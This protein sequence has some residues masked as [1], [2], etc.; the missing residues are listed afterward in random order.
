MGQELGCH[1]V[2][3]TGKPEKPA[4]SLYHH[5][6]L[7]RAGLYGSTRKIAARSHYLGSVRSGAHQRVGFGTVEI[8]NLRA[9]EAL[10]INLKKRAP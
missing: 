2:G 6:R 4:R 1:C 9:I 8:K 7:T 10:L 3:R 5:V